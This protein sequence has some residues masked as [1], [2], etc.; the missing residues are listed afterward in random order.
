MLARATLI[1]LIF[2]ISIPPCLAAPSDQPS[3]KATPDKT[4]PLTSAV[5]DWTKLAVI[6]TKTGER[7]DILNAPTPT[8]AQLESHV[9]TLQPGEAP[10]P[11]H[12]HP[13]EEIVIVKEGHLAA[14]IGDRVEKV[15]PGSMI[16]F[17]ANEP[18]GVSNA[19]ETP[20]TY[21]VIRILAHGTTGT[22]R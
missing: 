20:V 7:R 5:F 16:F 10:H 8:L 9:T 1:N 11:A 13:D 15:G 6:P 19:G 14:T 21:F 17:A 22:T 18:H 3:S 12:T 2:A 4:K